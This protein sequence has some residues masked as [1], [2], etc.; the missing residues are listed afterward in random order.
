MRAFLSCS[1]SSY[2]TVNPARSLTI[3]MS[4]VVDIDAGHDAGELLVAPELYEPPEE[5]SAEAL[6]LT[7]VGAEV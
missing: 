6:T 3:C 1:R 2:D 4:R 5:F 7:G